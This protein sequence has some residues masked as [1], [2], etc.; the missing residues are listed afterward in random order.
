[1]EKST[2]RIAFTILLLL[3]CSGGCIW[4]TYSQVSKFFKKVSFFSTSLVK[5]ESN[6]PEF[7]FC[8]AKSFNESSESLEIISLSEEHYDKLTLPV[9]VELVYTYE[10]EYQPIYYDYKSF[11]QTTKVNGKCKVFQIEGIMKSKVYYVFTYPKQE[12]ISLTIR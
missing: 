9:D 3:A 11:N 6:F 5:T 10:E 7:M 12:S 2:Y 4:I 8:N 1:M